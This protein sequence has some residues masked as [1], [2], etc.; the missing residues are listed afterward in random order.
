MASSIPPF[1]S[2]I[3]QAFEVL[4]GLHVHLCLW[5]PF[6]VGKVAVRQQVLSKKRTEKKGKKMDWMVT[7]S[8]IYPDTHCATS[9]RRPT[10]EWLQGVTVGVLIRSFTGCPG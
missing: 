2:K 6:G 4:G 7:T 10:K 1:P 9:K 3:D 8:R 5:R